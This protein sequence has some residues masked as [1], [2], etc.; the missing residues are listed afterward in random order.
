MM[1]RVAIQIP[2]DTRVVCSGT[3]THSISG[4]HLQPKGVPVDNSFYMEDDFIRHIANHYTVETLDKIFNRF[5]DDINFIYMY[6]DNVIKPSSKTMYQIHHNPFFKL[7]KN[8]NCK[9]TIQTPYN[10]TY[11]YD[12]HGAFASMLMYK[13]YFSEV[14][15]G[16]AIHNLCINPLR[17][18]HNVTVSEGSISLSNDSSIYLCST[19]SDIS[20]MYSIV[21]EMCYSLIKR[22]WEELSIDCSHLI[23]SVVVS[24]ILKTLHNKHKKRTIQVYS[25]LLT[26][27]SQQIVLD[28]RDPNFFN[29]FCD[30]VICTQRGEITPPSDKIIGERY[31]KIVVR[32]PILFG[33]D[34]ETIPV[35]QDF[36]NVKSYGFGWASYD[37]SHIENVDMDEHSMY[38]I[39]IKDAYPSRLYTKSNIVLNKKQ[40]GVIKRY[41]SRLF[42]SVRL[43][44]SET[45]LKIF[46]RL[47][48]ENVVYWKTDGGI[49]VV[50]KD[51]KV[52]W[53][54]SDLPSLHIDK[55]LK[56]SRVS[57]PEN[58][59][60]PEHL[61]SK[62]DRMTWAYKVTTER[63]TNLYWANGY[64]S[65]I[66]DILEH[67]GIDCNSQ[68]IMDIYGDL[69]LYGQTATVS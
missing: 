1:S 21:L 4:F 52:E 17:N 33:K 5:H 45:S 29:Y 58:I 67:N 11:E 35:V 40:F 49:V 48:I 57:F 61:A 3:P 39:D 55:V 64:E 41:D 32:K 20:D 10:H 25:M 38:H 24:Q 54:L 36:Q 43:D 14:D 37:V 60:I 26:I 28:N 53:L 18:V 23:Y 66:Q 42:Q 9:N 30:A 22:C 2:G 62:H 46:D 50:P 7:P 13:Y 8:F 63:S 12:V 31:Y 56:S 47:G 69:L 27:S 6:S 68:D 65:R 15:E 16:H 51:V 19:L 34:V 59:D 44:V